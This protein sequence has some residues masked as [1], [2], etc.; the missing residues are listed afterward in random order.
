M[1]T[2]YLLRPDHFSWL[3]EMAEEHNLGFTNKTL[4]ETVDHE[5]TFRRRAIEQQLA[6][7]SSHT[8]EHAH[9]KRMR[10]CRLPDRT[11]RE[12]ATIAARHHVNFIDTLHVIVAD[13]VSRISRDHDLEMSVFEA[14]RSVGCT[15][16][17]IRDLAAQKLRAAAPVRTH[18]G[19][20]GH[21]GHA[22]GH[23]PARHPARPTTR[24]TTRPPP[25]P[26]ARTPSARAAPKPV[27]VRPRKT[28]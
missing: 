1:A 23:S 18:S 7:L 17:L 6:R 9:W 27:V 15:S 13:A 16:T 12:V 11:A 22:R 21:A 28:R 5:L 20:H 24:P 14:P 10:N 2:A 25:K 19:G 3:L 8:L 4:K 26:V